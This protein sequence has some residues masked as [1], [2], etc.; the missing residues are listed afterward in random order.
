MRRKPLQPDLSCRSGATD[1]QATIKTWESSKRLQFIYDTRV[2]TS[3][4]LRSTHPS[5]PSGCQVQFLMSKRHAYGN[6]TEMAMMIDVMFIVINRV[7]VH[8]TQCVFAAMVL[9]SHVAARLGVG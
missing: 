1:P 2:R 3:C 6:T 9:V 4:V 7:A 5:G 8:K